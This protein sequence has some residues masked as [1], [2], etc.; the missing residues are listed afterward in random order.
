[1]A[2]NPVRIQHDVSTTSYQVPVTEQL[3]PDPLDPNYAG[4]VWQVQAL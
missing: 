3:L 1:M 4:H 2:S